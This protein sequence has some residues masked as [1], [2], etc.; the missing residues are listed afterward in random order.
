MR[1]NPKTPTPNTA[2]FKRARKA[3][4]MTRI[5]RM[6]RQIC[7]GRGMISIEACH[8]LCNNTGPRKATT[9]KAIPAKPTKIRRALIGMSP[10]GGSTP[11]RWKRKPTTNPIAGTSGRRY[12]SCFS[13]TRLRAKKYPTAH[14]HTQHS[15][16]TC[17]Q[18]PCF[19]KRNNPTGKRT[20][21]GNRS[22]QIVY[23]YQ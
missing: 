1:A 15:L 22:N 3:N 14:T 8:F 5:P 9:T 13:G 11:S 23:P 16:G 19:H 7:M 12:R 10:S 2:S 21:Q 6:P 17:G 18:G 20:D 4:P